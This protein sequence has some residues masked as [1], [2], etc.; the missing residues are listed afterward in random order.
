MVSSIRKKKDSVQE[1]KNFFIDMFDITEDTYGKIVY[2]IDNKPEW[3]DEA[4]AEEVI[5][6]QNG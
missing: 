6:G 1:P 4:I 5:N 3:N 2:F